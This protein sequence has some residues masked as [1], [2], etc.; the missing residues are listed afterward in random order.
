MS[1]LLGDNPPPELQH[2]LSN[3]TQVTQDTPATFIWHTANDAS[4]PV[5]NS[6]LFAQ[7]LSDHGVP[8][9]LHVYPHGAHGAGLAEQDPQ[10][11]SWTT[12]CA[13]WLARLGFGHDV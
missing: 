11:R 10:L 2:L 8:F 4:V 5:Q 6:L 13:G 9:E 3:E 7:A 12:L 1:S